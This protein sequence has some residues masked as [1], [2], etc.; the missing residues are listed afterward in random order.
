M[1]SMVIIVSAASGNIYTAVFNVI[2]QSVFIIDSSAEF[3]LQVTFQSFW[4]ANAGKGAVTLNIFDEKVDSFD[5]FL[6][7]CLPVQVI[8][9]SVI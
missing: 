8:V 9:P 7:L 2:D 1:E 3:T 6:I 5:C 4:L